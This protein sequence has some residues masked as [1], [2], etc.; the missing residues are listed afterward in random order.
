MF[1]WSAGQPA[2]FSKASPSSCDHRT[3]SVVSALRIWN[4]ERWDKTQIGQTSMIITLGGIVTA[5]CGLADLGR[6]ELP[7]S[8]YFILKG[9]PAGAFPDVAFACLCRPVLNLSEVLPSW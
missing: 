7:F 8:R 1:Y 3:V 5:V 4:E 2:L 9:K 6:K